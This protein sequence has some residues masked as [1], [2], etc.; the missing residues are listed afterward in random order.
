MF[1]RS[2][3][4]GSLIFTFLITVIFIMV[5]GYFAFSAYISPYL[6]DAN[7]MEML[8]IYSSLLEDVNEAELATNMPSEQDYDSAQTKLTDGGIN[9]FNEYGDIDPALIEESNFFP[10][11][12]ITITDKELA[13]L[14][15]EFIENP[16]N[17]EKVGINSE[18]VG[19]LNTKVLEIKIET[20]DSVTVELSIVVRL[21]MEYIKSEL[22]F[23][24]IILPDNL[25]LKSQSTIRLVEG[26]YTLI[27]GKVGVNDLEE[28]LNERMLEILVGALKGDDEN[29]TVQDLHEAAGE[30]ILSGIQ[31]ASNVFNT[32]ITFNN[33]SITFA[34]NES[35]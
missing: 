23:F 10:S 31:E 14:I 7:F 28:E 24:G 2:F 20:T 1:K 15:N 26:Q 22:A 25:Y 4:C 35:P 5:G 30:T 9:I 3:G 11:N 6:N 21:D 34:P 16:L 13:S 8:N 18:D 19:G 32:I 27:D 33:G 29:F 17:L 12:S